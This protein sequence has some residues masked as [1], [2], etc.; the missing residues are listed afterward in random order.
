M[1]VTINLNAG[2]G[3]GRGR[4]EAWLELCR[5]AERGFEAFPD[6]FAVWVD[7]RSNAGDPD[8]VGICVAIM[9]AEIVREICDG[10][11]CGV[12]WGRA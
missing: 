1:M 5:D 9:R 3:W 11:C 10:P 8:V 7:G 6:E 12:F 2:L 4:V